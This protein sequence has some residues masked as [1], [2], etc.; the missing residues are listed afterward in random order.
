M[1]RSKIWLTATSVFANFDINGDGVIDENEFLLLCKELFEEEVDD[2]E[3]RVKEIFKKFHTN[4][5][6]GLKGNEWERCYKEWIQ[7]IVEPVN[8]LVVVDVQND[9]IH[10]S[11]SLRNCKSKHD[12]Y[13][14]IK[15]IN[16]L[17]KTIDWNE[18]VYTLDYHPEDHISFYENLHLRELHPTS[19]I[20]KEEAVLYD[21]VIFMQPHVEQTLW[22]KH[23]VMGTWGSELHQD[24]Y[25]S[26]LSIQICKGQNPNV[27]AYSIFTRDDEETC[28][29]ME[30]AL[31]KFKATDLY[32][33][34]LALDVCVKETCLDA[35]KLGYKVV[36]LEDCC[37]GIDNDQIKKATN[38]IAE[39]GGLIITSDEVHSLVKQSKRSLILAHHAANKLHEKISS[40]IP[41]N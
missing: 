3:W 9:F 14:V 27:E 31:S 4:E 15:P 36:L 38:L 34:G 21:K 29:E 28:S 20:K 2:N 10:G 37:R 1:K 41:S 32:V 8:V 7:P 40:K 16:R 24:L 13:Q 33:C 12:G 39:N 19:Q 11:L 35:L 26:P 25:I 6:S 5:E 17:L 30:K 18:I 23:C 22:P